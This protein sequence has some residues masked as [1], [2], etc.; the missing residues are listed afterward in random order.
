MYFV[1]VYEQ[2]FEGNGK[3]EI[4]SSRVFY[5]LRVVLSRILLIFCF[6]HIIE[7]GWDEIISQTVSNNPELRT[8][9]SMGGRTMKQGSFLTSDLNMKRQGISVIW[10]TF[11]SQLD[12]HN[13]TAVEVM[14]VDK[15]STLMKNF[16]L[17]I[18]REEYIYFV[19]ENEISTI[20]R[21][22]LEGPYPYGRTGMTARDPLQGFLC[23]KYDKAGKP[24][25]RIIKPGKL[26]PFIPGRGGFAAPLQWSGPGKSQLERLSNGKY[27]HIASYNLDELIDLGWDGA[28]YV[29]TRG[30]HAVI[31]K[32]VPFINGY[33]SDS[34]D[35]YEPIDVEAGKRAG[36]IGLSPDEKGKHIIFRMMNDDFHH[37]VLTSNGFAL[38]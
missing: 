20:H 9:K 16:F 2:F 27:R 29:S 19:K 31:D 14:G 12:D 34:E 15:A 37:V 28:M 25:T 17:N 8:G 24:D 7:K 13:G 11:L 5:S 35:E 22:P 23:L 26:T 30:R 1:E 18:R 6:A 10:G 4:F 32:Y 36:I 21:N 38:P 33:D 3:Y